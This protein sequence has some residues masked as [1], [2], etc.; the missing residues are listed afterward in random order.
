MPRR[1]PQAAHVPLTRWQAYQIGIETDPACDESMRRVWVLGQA[2]R[3]EPGLDMRRFRRALAKLT[4]RH[5]SLRLRLVQ[6]G[7]DWRAVIDPPGEPLLREIDLGDMDEVDLLARIAE[8][9]YAPMPLLDAP[10]AETV[11]LHCGR[12]GDVVI[13]RVHHAIADGFGMV[14][15]VEDLLKFIVGMP[16]LTPATS[17]LEYLRAFENLP[18]ARQQAADAFWE[19]MH[20]DLAPPGPC[21]RKGRGLEPLW[22][23]VGDYEIGVRDVALTSAGRARLASRA[24]RSGVGQSSLLFTAFLEAACAQFGQ[25]RITFAT[26]VGRIDQ[27]L[28]TYIGHATHVPVLPYHARGADRFEASASDLAATLLS[29]MDHLPHEAASRGGPWRDRLLARG[30]FPEQF[31]LREAGANARMRRSL[32]GKSLGQPFQHLGPYRLTPVPYEA[33]YRTTAELTMVV[34]D[35]QGKG[36]FHF[37]YDGHAYSAAEIEALSDRICDLVGADRA[38]E[39]PA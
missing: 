5:D 3:V 6:A 23:S 35:P 34:E 30:I 31:Q 7:G 12:A 16:M 1:I 2:V 8:I 28:A 25:D 38:P 27:R 9:T 32:F 4:E 18:P 29:C 19:E 11:I 21:G 37:E 17:H 36:G 26:L 13:L 24:D 20:R 15:L 14:V 10:L 22:R 39:R 33:Q